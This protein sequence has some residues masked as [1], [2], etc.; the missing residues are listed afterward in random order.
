[1]NEY[2]IGALVRV[3]A[4]FANAAGAPADPTIVRAKVKK[5]SGTVTSYLYGTDVELVRD[6]LG[7]FHLDINVDQAEEWCYRF[8]GTGAVQA[9]DENNFTVNA[10]C[11]A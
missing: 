6:G 4:S 7:A 5:P 9:V 2:F 8:E 1:M 3:A 11:F 10:G